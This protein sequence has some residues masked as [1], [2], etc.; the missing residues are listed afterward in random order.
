MQ[1]SEFST[2]QAF[3]V[4]TSDSIAMAA[5]ELAR[6]TVGALMVVDENGRLSGVVTDRDLALRA[7]T[8]DNFERDAPVSKFMSAPAVSV[9]EDDPLDDAIGMMRTRGIRRIPV[10]RDGRPVGLLALDD[11]LDVM[12]R[13][14]RD[15]SVENHVRR[16]RMLRRARIEHSLEEVEELYDQIKS[17][18]SYAKWY[19]RETLLEEIDELKEAFNRLLQRMD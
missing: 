2:P 13:A 7:V 14:L 10:C 15:L 16:G 9:A 4:R 19:A 11:V 3:T 17:R 8:S 18:L 1:A 12:T 5:N 6:H